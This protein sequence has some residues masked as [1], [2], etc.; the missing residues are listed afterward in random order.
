MTMTQVKD[1]TL[2]TKT[3]YIGLEL[4]KHK[5]LLGGGIDLTHIKIKQID[6][7]NLGAFFEALKAFKTQFNLQSDCTIK[8]CMEAGL[9]GFS[10]YRMLIA[11]GLEALIVDSASLELNRR[12]RKAK[13]DGIDVKKLVQLLYRFNHGETG[14]LKAIRVPSEAEE[15]IRR[16]HREYERLQ[17][18]QTQHVNRIMGLLATQGIKLTGSAIRRKDFKSRLKN[19]TFRTSTQETLREYLQKELE[20]EYERY[21][22]THAQLR[23]VMKEAQAYVKSHPNTRV[24]EYVSRLTRLKGVGFWGAFKLVTEWFGWRDFNNRKEVGSAAG[25][26][27]V[28]HASGTLNREQ[29]ISKAGNKRIRRLIVELAWIWLRYQTNSKLSRWF[30]ERFS[31]GKRVKRIGIVGLARKLLITFWRY[32]SKGIL[33]SDIELKASV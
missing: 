31:Q 10:V 27:G 5:W 13:T 21:E 12:K 3:L 17:K 11:N 8:V 16:I 6:S 18:E 24:S 26:T 20:R 15:D 1:Y 32:L 22:L 25:L 29:G 28:P 9:D 4:S 2:N 33:P 14:C 19:K 7:W 30:H 23:D